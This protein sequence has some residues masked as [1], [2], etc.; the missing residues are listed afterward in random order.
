MQQMIRIGPR[1]SIRHLRHLRCPLLTGPFTV[2]GAARVLGG[3]IQPFLSKRCSEDKRHG[4][5]EPRDADIGNN[6]PAFHLATPPFLPRPR[7]GP[8]ERC[9][10]LHTH[11]NSDTTLSV[12]GGEVAVMGRQVLLGRK[13]EADK[14]GDLSK[15]WQMGINRIA[16]RPPLP[17]ISYSM[18]R[19]KNWQS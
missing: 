3:Y 19:R 10:E 18:S 11:L 16:G 14:V 6:K 13:E 1:Y 8:R 2:V 5:G 12:R 17:A 7:I 4:S 15:C 9:T